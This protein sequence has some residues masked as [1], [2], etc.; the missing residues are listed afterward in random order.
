MYVSRSK[1]DANP[2]V[3]IYVGMGG[4]PINS[5]ASP[6]KYNLGT[7]VCIGD[8]CVGLYVYK[9][10]GKVNVLTSAPVFAVLNNRRL[11]Y[12]QTDTRFSCFTPTNA[13]KF[14]IFLPQKAAV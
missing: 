12:L 13:K 3:S 7:T 1:S 5:I 10:P 6:S 14:F 8:A 4:S 2:D 9:K 11:H